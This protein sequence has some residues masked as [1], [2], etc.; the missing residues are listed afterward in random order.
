MR[1]EWAVLLLTLTGRLTHALEANGEHLNS[2]HET[3]SLINHLRNQ[4]VETAW[5]QHGGRPEEVE[6]DV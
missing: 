4:D 1:C 5:A 6:S 3:L 2:L